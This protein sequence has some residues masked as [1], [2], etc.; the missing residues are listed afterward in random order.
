M[1]PVISKVCSTHRISLGKT[2]EDIACRELEGRGYAI[3]ERRYRTLVG[4]IDI[5][6]RD[7]ETFVFVEVKTR[8]G[9]DYGMPREAVSSSKQHKIWQMATD[10]VQRHEL[11]GK[12][13]R[14]DVV[15]VRIDDF[16]KAEVEVIPDAFEAFE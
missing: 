12:G 15:E 14:F 2:G 10:Y 1:Q 7:G 6:A 5:V 8:T 9:L 16:G 11:F 4:E 3:L 13:C